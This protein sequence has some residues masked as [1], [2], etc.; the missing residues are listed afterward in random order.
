MPAELGFAP[1]ACLP[2]EADTTPATA[3]VPWHYGDP[4]GEQRHARQLIDTTNLQVLQVAGPEA[5]SWLTS[6]CSKIIGPQPVRALNL[7]AAGHVL[8]EFT[9]IP[10]PDEHFLL[11]TT[12]PQAQELLEYLTK[13]IFWA[14]VTVT[15]SDL[16]VLTVLGANA[17]EVAAAAPSAVAVAPKMWSGPEG[18]LVL[19][20][21]PAATWAELTSFAQ[22]A[23][24][25]ALVAARV[26]AGEPEIGVDTDNKTI[27]HE[28]PEWLAGPAF[29]VDLDKG[30]YRG[31]ETVARV[32]NLGQSPRVLVVLQLD[33][34]T[35]ELP[36]P[37]AQ[38]F[39]ADSPRPVGILRTVVHHE[40]FGPI[41]L[42]TIKQQAATL[43]DGQL[44]T[45]Q[46]A[47]QYPTA[48][49]LD[50]L[51]RPVGGGAGKAAIQKLRG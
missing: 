27:A 26:Y 28:V 48:A 37:G 25:M 19:T 50:R 20:A 18:A 33:G 2:R 31:Q 38:I 46:I 35:P 3:D 7:D 9:V 8:H 32:H 13:M 43:S 34:S 17:K 44:P 15:A 6:L 14:Q 23:G 4:F 10:Q 21:T 11:V 30:C 41:A 45:F 40:S 51:P 16:K 42:A 36:T 1:G 47:G 49:M 5:A 22:P 12:S 39:S 29:A 24:M